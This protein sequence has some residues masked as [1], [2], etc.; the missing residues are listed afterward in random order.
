MVH[1]CVCTQGRGQDITFGRGLSPGHDECGSA[2]LYRGF[3]G[4]SPRGGGQPPPEAESSVAFE[5]PAEEPNL[6][7]V[8]YSFLA[9]RTIGR[10][11]GTVCRLSSVV[12]L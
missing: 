6:S 10:A 7:L 9:D 12:C 5:A 8:T 2:S 4:Q 11:Y 1:R 3:R